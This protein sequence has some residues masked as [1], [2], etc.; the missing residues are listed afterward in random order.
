LAGPFLNYDYGTADKLDL[1]NSPQKRMEIEASL[2]NNIRCNSTP[3]TQRPKT[4][5][6]SILA[7]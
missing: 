7:Q 4:V 5:A 3:M 6:F 1:E 2:F